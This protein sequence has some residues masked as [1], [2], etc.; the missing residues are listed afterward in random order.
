MGVAAAA[1]EAEEAVAEGVGLAVVVAA[2]GLEVVDLAVG[3]RVLVAAPSAAE[4]VRVVAQS[5]VVRVLAE[6]PSVAERVLAVPSEEARV[7]VVVAL[8]ALDPI[9]EAL[10]VLEALG[11]ARGIFRT[12][13][14]ETGH[15]SVPD[16]TLAAAIDQISEAIGLR[17]EIFPQIVQELEVT[18]QESVIDP[19][20]A[21]CPQIARGSEVPGLESEIGLGSITGPELPI[22]PIMLCRDWAIGFPMQAVPSRTTACRT[23]SRIDAAT[24]K[25]ACQIEATGKITD[26]IDRTTDKK[27]EAIVRT[28]GRETAGIARTIVRGTVTT[29][30][31][32]ARKTGRT[33]PTTITTTGTATTKGAGGTTCGTSIPAGWRLVSRHGD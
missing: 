27:T 9:S 10:P 13:A 2:A 24:C 16:R 1:G 14:R 28:I 33:G 29:D 5:V 18:V 15:R 4:H 19:R 8:A 21:H 25:T 22:V 6:A 32:I 31:T 23:T 26:K 12:S 30:K 11:L 20:L 17:L 7:L 3:E